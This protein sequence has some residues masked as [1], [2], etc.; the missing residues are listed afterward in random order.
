[1]A[2]YVQNV[3][4]FVN[5]FVASHIVSAKMELMIDFKDSFRQLHLYENPRFVS[6]IVKISRVLNHRCESN[7]G[8]CYVVGIRVPVGVSLVFRNVRRYR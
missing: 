5:L 7:F 2:R 3:R 8:R 4:E 1:M 6:E